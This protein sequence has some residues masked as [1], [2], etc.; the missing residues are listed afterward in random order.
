MEEDGFF[1]P[2][3]VLTQDEAKDALLQV[4]EELEKEKSTRFRLHLV[5]PAISAIAHHPKLVSAV[6]EAL[7]SKDIWLW[8]SDINIKEPQSSG[9]F[10]P[11]QDATYAG[12][13]PSKECLTAWVALSHPVGKLEGCLSFYPSSHKCGQLHHDTP[14]DKEENSN[15]LLSLGQYISMKHLGTLPNVNPVS[16]PLQGGQA[17]L[18]SFDCVHSSRTNQSSLPRVGLALRYMTA[19]VTQTKALREMAT[20]IS[21]KTESAFEREPQLEESKSTDQAIELGRIAQKEAMR[22]E[23]AN[24]FASNPGTRVQRSVYK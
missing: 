16:I 20:Y 14:R 9:Y 5:T 13:S 17:T 22:R 24:Y 23:E 19:N 1:G 10:A 3:D 21:G 2:L 15:N 12:L 8:S 6:Q 4:Q 7:G 11:H 18:H